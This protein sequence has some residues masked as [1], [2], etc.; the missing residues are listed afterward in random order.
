MY[1]KHGIKADTSNAVTYQSVM[2]QCPAG[3]ASYCYLVKTA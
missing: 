1:K 2:Q 3:Y